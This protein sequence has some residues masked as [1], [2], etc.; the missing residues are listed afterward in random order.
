MMMFDDPSTIFFNL[1]AFVPLLLI[2]IPLLM[3]KGGFLVAG[4]NMMS[5]NEKAKFDEKR[6]CRSAGVLVLFTVIYGMVF[7][8]LLMREIMAAWIV[9]A[10]GMV[11]TIGAA[12]GMNTTPGK[13]FLMKKG[14]NLD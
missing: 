2:A 14:D 6:V 8:E 1:V 12:F 10:A 3:G 11:L 9:F 5:K 4:F 13:R 7:I